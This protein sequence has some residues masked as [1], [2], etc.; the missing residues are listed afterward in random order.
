MQDQAKTCTFRDLFFFSFLC[1]Q[2]F[3]NCGVAESIPVS[4]LKLGINGLCHY[5][6]GWPFEFLGQV[7]LVCDSEFVFVVRL[8]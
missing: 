1:H 5:L 6:D 4:S 8:S 7:Q 2:T 3:M